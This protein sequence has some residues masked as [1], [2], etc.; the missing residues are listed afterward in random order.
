VFTMLFTSLSVSLQEGSATH[1]GQRYDLKILSMSSSSHIGFHFA[2]STLH[3][4]TK[5]IRAPSYSICNAAGLLNC[6]RFHGRCKALRNVSTFRLWNGSNGLRVSK[7]G[8]PQ[9]VLGN[10]PYGIGR[11]THDYTTSEPPGYEIV[12]RSYP[13]RVSVSKVSLRATL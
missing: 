12:I 10:P 1:R 4:R 11:I 5:D 3:R 6:H 9:N 13:S 8:L 2:Q 7:R